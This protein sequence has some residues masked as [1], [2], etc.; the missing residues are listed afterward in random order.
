MVFETEKTKLRSLQKQDLATVHSWR[1]DFDLR[2]L[3]MMHPYPVTLEHDT[4]WLDKI[5]NSTDNSQIVFAIESKSDGLLAGYINLKGIDMLHRQ[6]FLGIIIGSQ[7][8]Q[9]MGLGSE[10]VKLMLK[11]GFDFLGLEKI[12]LEV[13][14][15]NDVALKLYAK[16][17]FR[18]EGV[19]R[20][21][22]FFKGACHDVTRLAILREEW[23]NH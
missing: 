4:E 22:F 20:K 8:H 18:I 23:L 21:H 15:M 9:H 16:L 3:V 13:I 1:E 10:A 6:A 2:G 7:A 14:Q 19:F 11:Y 5:I 17:G 12:S